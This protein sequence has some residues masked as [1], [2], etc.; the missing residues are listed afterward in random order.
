MKSYKS[1]N[2]CLNSLD[3]TMTDDLE[4]VC[5]FR[6]WKV[7]NH[8]LFQLGNILLL[9]TFIPMQGHSAELIS[10]SLASAGLFLHLHLVLAHSLSARCLHLGICSSVSFT[11]TILTNCSGSCPPYTR[12]D[13]IGEDVYR[14]VFEP[15][16][17]SRQ[18]FEKIYRRTKIM[19]MMTVKEILT[20]DTFKNPDSPGGSNQTDY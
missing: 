19:E 2:C 5:H 16:K 14:T 17:V 15:L 9:L 8:W 12:F 6:E 13:D 20:T 1:F 7:W 3:F 11:A 4:L 18:V 10:R